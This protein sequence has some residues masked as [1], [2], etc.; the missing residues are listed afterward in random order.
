MLLEKGSD[1][2]YEPPDSG[3]YVSEPAHHVD[4]TR[5]PLHPAEFS[6]LGDTCDVASCLFHIVRRMRC[7]NINPFKK[8]FL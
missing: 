1:S 5:T 2:V 7:A 8:Y 3:V 4:K 6:V